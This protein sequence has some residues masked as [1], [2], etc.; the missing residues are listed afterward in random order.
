MRRG[1]FAAT[2]YNVVKKTQQTETRYQLFFR[3]TLS[4]IQQE[5]TPMKPIEIGPDAALGDLAS[6]AMSVHNVL[7]G[8]PVAIKG[9]DRPGILV[10]DG[11]VHETVWE[12]PAL[13]SAFTG[14]KTKAVRADIGGYTGIPMYVSAITNGDGKA[15]A[16]IG[17]IDV[18][19]T[20]T[21]NRFAEVSSSLNQQLGKHRR[22]AK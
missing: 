10:A 21:L 8:M 1:I 13:D 4:I 19:G 17:V 3:E 12:S 15:I 2:G 9:R 7:S 22:P 20:L 18:S 5:S 14:A 6:L 11:A 16:V